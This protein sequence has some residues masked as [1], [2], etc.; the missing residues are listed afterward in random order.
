M[1]IDHRHR[2]M[3]GLGRGHGTQAAEHDEAPVEQREPRL[4]VPLHERL[5]TGHQ[6]AGGA[7]TDQRPPDEQHGDI[8][9][10]AE[11]GG[12]DRGNAEQGR[13]Q[14]A[15]SEPVDQDAERQL[16]RGEGQEIDGGDQAEHPR[17]ER[18]GTD[19]FVG[20]RAVDG[21][22]Q[23]GKEISR[24]EGREDAQGHPGQRRPVGADAGPACAIGHRGAQV[25]TDAVGRKR[26]H[27]TVLRAGVGSGMRDLAR[28]ERHRRPGVG[29]PD[30][31]KIQV[32]A[33]RAAGAV[34]A[35][36]G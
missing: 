14:A 7:K 8:V 29:G 17:V 16:E 26:V 11:H 21:A 33:I 3:Y 4:I 31:T 28:A 1:P 35:G 25:V 34:A 5:E 22:E 30:R 36:A 24:G 12:S 18:Q 9:T 15:R 10:E 20:E 6:R 13:A 32:A 27:R 19:E 23:V 2:Q